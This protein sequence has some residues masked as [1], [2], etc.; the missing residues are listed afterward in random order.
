LE[1]GHMA[2][3]AEVGDVD[4]PRQRQQTNLLSGAEPSNRAP[5]C[6]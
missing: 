6:R 5:G 1:Q 2:G 4:A 3:P